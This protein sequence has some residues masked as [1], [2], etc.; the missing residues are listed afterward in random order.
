MQGH[1]AELGVLLKSFFSL[2]LPCLDEITLCHVAVLLLLHTS[3]GR[4]GYRGKLPCCYYCY[5]MV[6]ILCLFLL[7]GTQR[8]S[9]GVVPSETTAQ[10]E[11]TKI[12]L[13]GVS[14]IVR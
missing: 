14:I 5:F 12:T 1:L 3:A 8:E 7:V 9:K 4:S 6:K 13:T 2:G 10:R 11:G